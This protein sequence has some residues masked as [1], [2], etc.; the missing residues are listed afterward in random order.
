MLLSVSPNQWRGI[1]VSSLF[2]FSKSLIT[3]F[4]NFAVYPVLMNDCL[5]TFTSFFPMLD[6]L[7]HLE[8]VYLVFGRL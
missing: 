4:T 5:M 3:S 1:I 8:L 7:R 2:G 6:V